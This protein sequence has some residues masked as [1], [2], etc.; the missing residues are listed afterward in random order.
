MGSCIGLLVPVFLCWWSHFGWQKA[1]RKSH[2]ACGR[3]SL[4]LREALRGFLAPRASFFAGHGPGSPKTC[5]PVLSP[6]P[7]QT[8][9]SDT[10]FDWDGHEWMDVLLCRRQA[11]RKEQC[12]WRLTPIAVGCGYCLARSGLS[13]MLLAPDFVGFD[14]ASCLL[15]ESSCVTFGCLLLSIWITG[16]GQV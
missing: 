16:Q 6:A 14:G 1:S 8:G 13:G 12:S 11:V 3:Q 2:S 10:R 4:C 7:P 9:L 15:P 5:G